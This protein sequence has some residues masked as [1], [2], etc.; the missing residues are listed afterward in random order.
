MSSKEFEEMNEF[1]MD[2]MDEMDIP[3]DV[4]FSGFADAFDDHAG[5]TDLIHLEREAIHPNS[6]VTHEMDGIQSDHQDSQS[7]RSSSPEDTHQDDSTSELT[8]DEVPFYTAEELNDQIQRSMT[9]L[10]QSM[11]RSEMSRNMLGQQQSAG[12]FR[13]GSFI[14]NSPFASIAQNRT[15]QLNNYMSQMGN[16]SG[17]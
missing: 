11:H 4:D 3:D 13:L 1:A 6:V 15:Q 8:M 7:H 2:I 5:I 9:K 10:V 12:M 16:H 14:S 17:L